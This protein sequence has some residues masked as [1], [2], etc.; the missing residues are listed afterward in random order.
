MPTVTERLFGHESVQQLKKSKSQ[1][2]RHAASQ[3]PSQV[4]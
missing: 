1:H 2:P 4:N 3:T